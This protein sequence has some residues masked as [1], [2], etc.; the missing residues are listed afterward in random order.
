MRKLVKETIYLL[1]GFGILLFAHDLFAGGRLE[2][3]VQTGKHYIHNVFRVQ[4]EPQMAFWVEDTKGTFIDNIYVTKSF[5]KNYLK[6]EVKHPESL[7]VWLLRYETGKKRDTNKGIDAV[8]GATPVESFKKQWNIPGDFSRDT[9]VIFAEI[10]NLFDYNETYKKR[11]TRRSNKELEVSSGVNGQPSV[12]Y[13][14]TIVLDSSKQEAEIFL[15]GIGEVQGKH[16]MVSTDI[17]KLTSA[18]S[19]VET[20]H[21]TYTP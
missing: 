4:M 10:N 15:S 2:V 5:Y 8:S 20:I 6:G 1:G 11:L 21:V 13:Y 19:I 17:K 14:G 16:G 9:L 3:S 12:I 7:P 18:R